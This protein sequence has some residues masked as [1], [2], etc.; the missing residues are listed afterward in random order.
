MRRLGFL[1]FPWVLLPWTPAAQAV[2][3][4]ANTDPN[5]LVLRNAA[6]S[7]TYLVENVELKRDVGTIT[8][9]SGQVSF[10]PRFW[11]T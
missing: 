5:Y 1:L 6:P 4:L 10:L 3:P 9:R 11:G 2:S 8:L 7:E